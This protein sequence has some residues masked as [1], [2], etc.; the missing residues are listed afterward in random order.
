MQEI[1][2]LHWSLLGSQGEFRELQGFSLHLCGKQVQGY[3]CPALSRPAQ[4]ADEG[5]VAPYTYKRIKS[6]RQ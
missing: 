1:L 6:G 5:R 2:G 3:E 4:G